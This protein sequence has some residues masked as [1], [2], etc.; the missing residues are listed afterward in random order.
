MKLEGIPG[1]V[2]GMGPNGDAGEGIIEEGQSPLEGIEGPVAELMR[3]YS[4]EKQNEF[5]RAIDAATG[6]RGIGETLFITDRED[7]EALMS[8]LERYARIAGPEGK[9]DEKK[10]AGAR[11]REIFRKTD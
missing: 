2:V 8:N 3:T 7:I 1:H 11:I 9:N 5:D 6:G 10:Q 4:I